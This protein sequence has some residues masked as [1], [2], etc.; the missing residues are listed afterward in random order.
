M[1]PEVVSHYR[2]RRRLGAGGMGEVYLADDLELKRQVAIK[3][4]TSTDLTDH[5]V[6]K[7][8][9]REA[10]AA[11]SLDHPNIC[12]VHEVGTE[13]DLSFIVM[14]YVE[15]ET[16]AKRLE[17]GV[18]SPN[19]ALRIV[20]QVAEALAAAHRQ[21]VVHRDI[22]PQNIVLTNDERVKV[23][24]FGLARKEPD[25]PAGEERTITDTLDLAGTPPY[26]SPE[27]LQHRPVDGRS[28]LF[29]LG[30]VYYECLTGRRAFSGRTQAEIVGQVLHV[31]PPPPSSVNNQLGPLH[32]Q[33][34]S[35]LLAKNPAKRV[36]T[37]EEA[38]HLLE[39]AQVTDSQPFTPP[40]D[41][42]PWRKAFKVSKIGVAAAGLALLVAIYAGIAPHWSAVPGTDRA[43]IRQAVIGPKEQ[44]YLAV[45]PLAAASLDDRA[46]AGGL[47][48][49]L[50]SK[51]GTLSGS[52]G[53]QVAPVSMMRSLDEPTVRAVGTEFGVGHAMLVGAR[54]E[55]T[56]LHAT[57]T[58]VEAPGGREVETATVT[59][60][61]A[62][63]F[64]LQDLVIT[65]APR[66]LGLTLTSDEI[67]RLRDYGTELPEAY[68]LYLRGRGYLERFDRGAD[69]DRAVSAFR[70]ALQ[71]D[72][73]YAMAHA[74]LG[75]AYWEKHDQTNQAAYAVQS[76]AECEEAA[77]LDASL[78]EAH[79]CRGIAY[80]SLGRNNEA[81]VAFT[82][83]ITIDP[84]S[85]DALHG[86]AV[87][88]EQMGSPTD[89]E[90]T[91]RQVVEVRP[92]DWVGYYW[93]GAFY[94]SEARYADASE[95]FE[96]VIRLTPDNFAGYSNLGVSYV[97]QELW[98]EAFDA[99]ERSV[100]IR[101]SVSGYSNLATL[102][103]FQGRY[104]RAAGLY[105]DARNLDE[106]N[107]LI[108]GNLGDA[109]YWSSSEQERAA[110]AYGRALELAEELRA[111][112]PDDSPLLG[113]MALYNA[114]LGRS[115]R[116]LDLIADALG[117]APDDAELR[118]QA[119]QVYQQLGQTDEAVSQ[120]GQALN[121]GMTPALVLQNPW[122]ASIRDTEGFL[123]VV[124]SR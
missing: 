16:L 34:C 25:D 26:M 8:L 50:R 44:F 59:A 64:S 110:A 76:A 54:H 57:V 82:R 45:I 3:L 53:L 107:Y 24:D 36:Q 37:G 46:L 104:L 48:D 60:P 58:L 29:S 88:Y 9:L 27:Q 55:G 40:L 123:G 52:H 78:T 74:G 101:P 97:Y 7:N 71:I 12:A 72:P 79:V 10:Q 116:A 70:G 21:G 80:R 67:D 102:Y 66:L 118:L 33:L 43:A 85:P 99:L 63:F 17:R 31:D 86:L 122:F 22:K 23:L 112:T 6:R 75:A 30:A 77:A 62:E 13:G 121:R 41:A 93:L 61:E 95:A 1:L 32:D 124:A 119:A 114:M 20:F 117:L 5:Q 109:L 38:V 89:A 98:P 113:D 51:L 56:D 103:F 65:E 49:A 47:A 68:H 15:G 42:Q 115:A 39:L 96:E 19:E 14:Q 2:I 18:P 73:N 90:Q 92:Y 11:A 69:T 35:Q 84:T 111:T 105:E 4:L 81:V 28:D 87:V 120:L 91:H 106:G 83:A 100:E 94:V 108:W